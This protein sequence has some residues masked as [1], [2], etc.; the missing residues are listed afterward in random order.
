M[1]T[2]LVIVILLLSMFVMGCNQ[3]EEDSKNSMISINLEC[4]Q[5][6]KDEMCQ[7]HYFDDMQSITMFENAINHAIKMPGELNYIAEYEMTVT[8]MD[9][10]E[11][12]YDLSLGT[13][14]SMKGL[15]VDKSNTSQGYEI[16][17]EDANLL[18]ELLVSKE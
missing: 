5:T 7:D 11:L 16:P 9:N 18:R 6:H 12:R 2:K 4:F 13:D 1:K 10:T 8:F 3:S 14:Q 17:V 15:L